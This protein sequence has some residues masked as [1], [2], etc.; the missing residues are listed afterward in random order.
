ME[1]PL[2][3][4]SFSLDRENLNIASHKL[5]ILKHEIDK[6]SKSSTI[7]NVSKLIFYIYFYDNC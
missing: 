6:A 7:F 3:F 1:T 2:Q 5:K 4:H